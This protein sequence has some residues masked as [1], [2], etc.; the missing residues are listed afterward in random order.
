MANERQIG[1]VEEAV[2]GTEAV[3]TDAAVTTFGLTDKFDRPH[4]WYEQVISAIYQEDTKV[5]VDLI[6]GMQNIK[7][8]LQYLY[9]HGYGW[10][11]AMGKMEHV[12]ATQD[13]VTMGGLSAYPI[14]SR[15]IFSRVGADI[16]VAYGM[17][18]A[19]Y[20]LHMATPDVGE[21]PK[22]AWVEEELW[23]WS[24]ATHAAITED[25]AVIPPAGLDNPYGKGIENIS[26]K[27]YGG[28]VL[29]NLREV[30]IGVL[31]NLK[32]HGGLGSL[33]PRGVKQ[34]EGS[35]VYVGGIATLDSTANDLLAVARAAFTKGAS[36]DL[37]LRLKFNAAGSQFHD[38]KLENLRISDVKPVVYHKNVESY[39]FAG[40]AMAYSTYEP[41]EVLLEDGED[42]EAAP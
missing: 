1:W 42:Y 29:Y 19:S 24:T 37:N 13:K 7:V 10:K 35:K 31:N 41:L 11:Y 8:K 16:V 2:E 6:A 27:T 15:T 23:G 5:P 22:P 38:F 3:E 28:N 40:E 4:P 30:S 26:V 36:Q 32:L 9:Q 20:L 18:T 17:K 33:V 12:S 14:K 39:S 21:E 34:L 25:P